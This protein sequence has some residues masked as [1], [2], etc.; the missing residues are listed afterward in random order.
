MWL[1]LEQSWGT[2][3]EVDLINVLVTCMSKERKCTGM[4]ASD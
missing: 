2:K 3:Q 1:K 4:A